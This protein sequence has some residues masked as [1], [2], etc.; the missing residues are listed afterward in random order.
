MEATERFAFS[1]PRKERRAGFVWVWMERVHPKRPRVPQPK[2]VAI[3]TANLMD[4]DFLLSLDGEKFFTEPHYDGYAAVL[5]R[6]EAVTARELAPLIEEAWRC[7]APKE[8]AE[9]AAASGT[10][11]A[12]RAAKRAKGRSTRRKTGP[13]RRDRG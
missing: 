10:A 6:L 3:R 2:V 12:R 8:L 1:V 11:G 9:G 4:K 7:V 5:V 13:E